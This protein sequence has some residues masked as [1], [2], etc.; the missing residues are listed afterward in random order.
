M[1]LNGVPRSATDIS[2]ILDVTPLDF[3][4]RTLQDVGEDEAGH[5]DVSTSRT[6]DESIGV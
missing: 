2:I 4:E 1:A 3:R 5:S 6:V